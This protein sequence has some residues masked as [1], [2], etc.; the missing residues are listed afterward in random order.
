MVGPLGEDAE[1]GGGGGAR[2]DYNGILERER[3]RERR[4]EPDRA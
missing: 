2:E 3:E 1:G 4:G